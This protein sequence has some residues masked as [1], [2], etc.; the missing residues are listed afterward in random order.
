MTRIQQK[1]SGTRQLNQKRCFLSQ[2][3]G[4]F[5]DVPQA[6]HASACLKH[7]FWILML[8]PEGLALKLEVR[9]QAI[10]LPKELSVTLG[11]GSLNH[12][13][14][15]T[16]VHPLAPLPQPTPLPGGNRVFGTSPNTLSPKCFVHLARF[17]GQSQIF[18]TTS[19]LRKQ[20]VPKI[21][22]FF[23]GTSRWPEIPS[24]RGRGDVSLGQL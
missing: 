16:S 4:F 21:P 8:V 13:Y 14:A 18:G 23:R 6:L 17:S 15:T 11:R 2:F 5:G 24:P 9:I 1:A 20:V 19:K 10:G 12:P 22:P 7:W 3:F